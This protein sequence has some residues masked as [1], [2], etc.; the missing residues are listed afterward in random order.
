MDSEAFSI[1]SDI[2]YQLISAVMSSLCL[3]AVSVIPGG[4]LRLLIVV[5]CYYREV[6]TI[7]SII[8]C[9]PLGSVASGCFSA[10]LSAAEWS[11]LHGSILCIL[12]SQSQ[13]LL[14]YLFYHTLACVSKAV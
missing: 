5:V 6:V 3:P 11:R 8:E 12:R 7:L 13:F 1:I 9:R 14:I 2:S 10:E 4:D